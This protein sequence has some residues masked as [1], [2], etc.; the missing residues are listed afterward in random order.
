MYLKGVKVRKSNT[1]VF[2]D[3]NPEIDKDAKGE[4][5]ECNYVSFV[6]KSDCDYELKDG[7][8]YINPYSAKCIPIIYGGTYYGYGKSKKYNGDKIIDG[9]RYKSYSKTPFYIAY[10]RAVYV[11]SIYNGVDKY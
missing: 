9:I 2:R 3:G 7:V 5:V 4:P 6:K 11:G 1:L 10:D 8:K